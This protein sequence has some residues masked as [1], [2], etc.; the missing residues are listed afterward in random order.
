ML[1]KRWE[2]MLARRGITQAVEFHQANDVK[3][4]MWHL[5]EQIPSCDGPSTIK[6][7][8]H[9]L[10]CPSGQ[11]ELHGVEESSNSREYM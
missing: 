10:S 8:S 2:T 5:G 11:G 4:T 6:L 1:V 7:P 3:Y 9:A